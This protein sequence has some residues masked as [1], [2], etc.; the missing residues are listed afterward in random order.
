MGVWQSK[1]AALNS[2][3]STQVG[4][5]IVITGCTTGTGYELAKTAISKG[6][7]NLILLNRPSARST[8][9]LE[10]MT[11]LAKD[12]ETIVT[13]V[14]CDLLSFESVRAGAATILEKFPEGI[15]ILC[16]NAGIMAFPDEASPAGYDIQMQVNHLSHFLLTKLLLPLI[17][18]KAAE[19]GEARIVNHSSIARFCGAFPEGERK[20]QAKYF[21]KNGGNLG[22]DSIDMNDFSGARFERYQQTKLANML[23]TYALVDKL[24]AAKKA[25][26]K[27]LVAHPGVSATALGGNMAS[28][29][30]QM[31]ALMGWITSF[32]FQTSADG[33]MGITRCCFDADASTGDFYGPGPGGYSGNAVAI[34]PEENCTDEEAKKIMWELSEAAIEESFEIV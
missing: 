22:G 4:K 23:F 19:V 34:T 10:E 33:A 15:D 25:N 18:K 20:L 12:S 3:L 9:L 1:A 11:T 17:E 8:S 24:A 28:T 32:M 7:K 30:V 26:I 21:E 13:A 31:P 5:T 6:V 27:V 14:D 2:T 29:G 16:N